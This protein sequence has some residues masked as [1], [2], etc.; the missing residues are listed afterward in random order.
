MYNNQE[1]YQNLGDLLKLIELNEFIMQGIFEILTANPRP[2][3]M[4]Q[5]SDPITL[6][7]NRWEHIHKSFTDMTSISASNQTVQSNIL[8]KQYEQI[9]KIMESNWK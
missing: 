4:S 8:Q 1:I 5:I 7:N 9:I 3:E 2:Q 6:Q